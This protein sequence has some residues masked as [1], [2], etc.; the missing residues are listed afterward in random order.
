MRA[1]QLN[2]QP[3]WVHYRLHAY[4]SIDDY[5][6]ISHAPSPLDQLIAI[7]AFGASV[8][9][10]RPVRM[11]VPERQIAPRPKPPVRVRKRIDATQRREVLLCALVLVQQVEAERAAEREDS[12]AA[13]Q[14]ALAE[15]EYERQVA[16]AHRAQLRVY[17]E[18]R[19]EQVRAQKRLWH[20]ERPMP[21]WAKQA[22]AAG[23][24][25]PKGW[26]P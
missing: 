12:E 9:A 15:R 1:H 13:R 25:T 23:W 22:M 20:G 16:A 11:P 5:D 26:K 19:R 2:G 4:E 8:F 7:E 17:V 3:F 24:K 6:V 10:S 18:E 14:V 21:E